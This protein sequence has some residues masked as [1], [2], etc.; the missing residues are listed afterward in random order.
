MQSIHISDSFQRKI[1]DVPGVFVAVVTYKRA[2]QMEGVD[3]DAHSLGFKPFPFFAFHF[4]KS[5]LFKTGE[6]FD[7]VRWQFFHELVSTLAL[8]KTVNFLGIRRFVFACCVHL[9]HYLR[10]NGRRL[11]ANRMAT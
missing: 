2:R 9:S 7:Q 8:L 6:T 3:L 4:K 1:A 11:Y 5:W 10:R